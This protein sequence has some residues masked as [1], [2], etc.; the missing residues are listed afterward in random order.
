MAEPLPA[1]RGRPGA[2][3]GA[4]QP[5]ARALCRDA[6]LPSCTTRCSSSRRSSRH[7][8]GLGVDRF[9]VL[10]DRSTDGT[11]AVPRR[12]AGRDDRRQRHP[13]FRGG[14]PIRRRCSPKIRETRAVRLWRDQ[15][16]DQFCDGQWAVVV[17]PDEFLALPD[18]GLPALTAGARRRGRRGRL[19]GDGRHVPRAACATSS[20]RRRRARFRL[21]DAWFFDARPHLDPAPGDRDAAGAAHG[22]SRQRGAALQHLG[23]PAA[24]HARRGGS[25]AGSPA[26]ATSRARSSTRRRSSSGARATSS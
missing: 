24:G 5:D 8:R 23:R 11:A 19:G 7:Y 22:L 13:L 20:A 10:D 26:T 18:G 9:I 6:L 1:R 12:P 3:P 14:S 4:A 2:A 17:D 16:I 25:A 15:M 21:D